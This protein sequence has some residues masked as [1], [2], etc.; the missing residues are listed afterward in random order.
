MLQELTI[1]D[2]AIIEKMDLEFQRQ[3]PLLTGE[4]GAGKSIMSDP[5]G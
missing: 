5:V 2:F 4:S 1:R 3:I